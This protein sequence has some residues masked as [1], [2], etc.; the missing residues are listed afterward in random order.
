MFQ[1]TSL[2]YTR[3]SPRLWRLVPLPLLESKMS[4]A[5]QPLVA[6]FLIPSAGE[7]HQRY[8]DTMPIEGI[9]SSSKQ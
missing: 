5:M 3:M 8:I 6:S 9:E 7:T 2:S 4:T 1:S